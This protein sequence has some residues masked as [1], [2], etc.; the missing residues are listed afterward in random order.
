M[1]DLMT[2]EGVIYSH[3]WML[4]YAVY[5]GYF[6]PFL[7]LWPKLVGL[8]GLEKNLRPVSESNLIEA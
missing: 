7:Q 2:E 1:T 5:F 8:G 6:F 4:G 3:I